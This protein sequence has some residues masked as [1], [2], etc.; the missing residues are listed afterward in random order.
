[1]KWI[2][3]VTWEMC[4]Y[5]TVEAN[6]LEEAMETAQDKSGNMPL[7]LDGEYVEGS[8]TLSWTDEEMLKEIQ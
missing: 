1:M 2:M 3:P 8:W 5:I 4:A 6:S 7:P